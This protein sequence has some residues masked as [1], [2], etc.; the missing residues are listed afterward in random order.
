MGFVDY[1][2]ANMLIYVLCSLKDSYCQMM[3]AEQNILYID[4]YILKTAFKIVINKK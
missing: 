3:Y 1:M 4:K 2:H